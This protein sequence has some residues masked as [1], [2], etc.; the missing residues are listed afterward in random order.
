MLSVSDIENRQREHGIN[1]Y[2]ISED[3]YVSVQGNVNLT[4]KLN[5]EK[6]PV[7]FDRIDGYFDMSNNGLETLE[8]AP[9]TVSKDCNCS[10]TKLSSLYVWPTV[11]GE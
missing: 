5:G 3:F 8:G 11:V 4:E 2:H 6:L 10:K 1:N 7:K 9:K